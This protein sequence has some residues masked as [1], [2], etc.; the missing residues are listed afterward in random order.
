MDIDVI[1]V[2]KQCVPFNVLED[3]FLSELAAFVEVKGYKKGMY[4]FRQGEAS[5][6]ALFLIALGMGEVTATDGGGQETVISYRRQ[7]D[8]FGETALLTD[9]PYI[10]SVRA[11][12]DLVCLLVH[13]EKIQ[14][15]IA[16]R[17]AFS[18]CFTTLLSE[19]LRAQYEE[20]VSPQWYRAH[21]SNESPLLRKRI[22]DLMTR[23]PVTCDIHEPVARVAFLMAEN[24]ISSVIVTGGGGRPVGLITERDLVYKVLTRAS[25]QVEEF[26]AGLIMDDQLVRIKESDFYN[27]A[28]LKMIK[29]QVKHL[30]VM[31]GEKLTGILTVRDLIKTRS[32]G[33]LWATDNIESAKNLG[34]L[35][36]IGQEADS[37][38]N[39]LVAERASVPELFEIITELHDRLTCRVIEFCQLEME[40]KGYG[41]P[42][43]DYCWINMGSAGRREQTLRTDQDNAI[44]Y[45]GGSP[46]SEKYFSLL[47]PRVVEEL[48]RAGFGWCK[49]GT[50]AS[51]P[52]WCRSILNWKD[53]VTVWTNRAD[54]EDTRSLSILLDFRLVFGNMHLAGE[55]WQHIFEVFK[56]P[57]RAAHFLAEEELQVRVPLNIFGGFA[58]ERTGPQKNEIN[59]KLICRHIVNCIRIFAV[60]NSIA[61]PSTLERLSQIKDKGVLPVEDAEFIQ[62]SFEFLMMLRIRENLRKARE[63]KEADNYINPYSLSRFEQSLIK[64]AFT[65]ITRLQKLTGSRFKIY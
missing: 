6:H 22:S 40:T 55:L 37:F 23:S 53:V 45:A 27:R 26:T 3:N 60:K 39:A 30:V 4:V 57:V 29:H 46:D 13:R 62:N 61:G 59:L 1:S 24:G 25:W 43:V 32:A 19:R 14:H 5:L 41:R 20:R 52:R 8:F 11:A 42:P 33:S 15:L 9:K 64:N 7:Y 51:N 28:L 54:P 38:L 31:E 12:G 16:N 10:V 47:G 44:I 65:A 49:G 17:P 34:E 50:M 63:G 35:A 48:V 56:K 2:L 36:R 21:D 58:F 18:G